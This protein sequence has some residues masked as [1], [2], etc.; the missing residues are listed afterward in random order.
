LFVANGHLGFLKETSPL[1]ESTL[2]PDS[3]LK[4]LGDGTFQDISATAGLSDV[5]RARGASFADFDA[6]GDVDIVV[7]YIGQSPGVY[8]NDTPV[9]GNFARVSLRGTH[10]NRDGIG[11][12]LDVTL[13]PSGATLISE[14]A[15]Y[16]GFGGTNEKTVHV[17]VGD[18]TSVDLLQVRWP[19]DAVQTLFDLPVNM[20]IDIVEPVAI[21]ENIMGSTS[22]ANEGQSVN[23][24]ADIRTIEG[25]NLTVSYQLSLRTPS[26]VAESSSVFSLPATPVSSGVN[27]SLTVPADMSPYVTAL[28]ADVY[29]VLSVFDADGGR[30]EARVPLTIQ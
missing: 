19:S 10:S 30:H 5:R 15:P 12:L 16:Y 21:S 20:V 6:D 8:R 9:Q 24:T 18:D 1:I 13:A 2:A 23:V 29:L 3:F 28:P 14:L 7:G 27:P 11:A 17:G 4:N 25:S 22:T 26:G